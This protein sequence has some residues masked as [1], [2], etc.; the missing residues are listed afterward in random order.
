MRVVIEDT[1]LKVIGARDEPTL[2]SNESTAPN[3]DLC[4]FECFH[5]GAS[6]V[7]VYVDGTVIK[8]RQEPWLRGMEI[9][10]FDAVG[11]IKYFTLGV[12][13]LKR[14]NEIRDLLT[15]TSKSMAVGT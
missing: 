11:S 10:C 2:S 1:Q 7:V 14:Y 3:W 9:N 4:D 13:R 12:V 6:L 15:L 5:Q 8:A